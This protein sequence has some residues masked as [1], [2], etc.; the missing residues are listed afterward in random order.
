M[1]GQPQVLKLDDEQTWSIPVAPA[2]SVVPA[3]PISPAV[4]DSRWRPSAGF[5]LTMAFLGDA[6]VIFASL[7]LGF[8]LRFDSGLIPLARVSRRFLFLLITSIC[9]P[10][11]RFFCWPRSGICISTP[12]ICSYVFFEPPG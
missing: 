12:G 9:W 6:V 4:P 7:C 1:N 2:I 3:A 5:V 10:E 11:A 8:W